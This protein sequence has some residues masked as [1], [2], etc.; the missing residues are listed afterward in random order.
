MKLTG[1]ERPVDPVGP[2]FGP[3]VAGVTG[4]VINSAGVTPLDAWVE[5]EVTE[6]DRTA[7]QA[8]IT[9]YVYNPDYGLSP[10][11]VAL[12]VYMTLR[13]W[14]ADAQAVSSQWATLT[15]TQ[16]DAVLHTIVDRF[17]TLCGRLGDL[18]RYLRID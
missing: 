10:E 15:S 3:H 5:G 13:D 18:L 12:R 11:R 6:T 9:L 4:L 2:D 8:A 14:E 16:K 1:F 7:I 17:G